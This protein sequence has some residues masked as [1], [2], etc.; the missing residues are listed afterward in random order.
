M[1]YHN[2]GVI[3]ITITITVTVKYKMK[4]HP[5]MKTFPNKIDK[6]FRR[7]RWRRRRETRKTLWNR[8]KQS[9]K[10]LTCRT[11]QQK[12]FT[13]EIE[14]TETTSKILTC[15]QFFTYYLFYFYFIFVLLLNS[16]MLEC[17]LC[18]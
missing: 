4:T 10:N 18:G 7:E 8:W 6:A 15:S 16:R 2:F 17:S 11:I 13:L 5:S 3:S 14:E 9:E 12:R 1:H